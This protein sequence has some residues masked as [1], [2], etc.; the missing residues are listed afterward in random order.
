MQQ[1]VNPTPTVVGEGIS[2]T[3]ESGRQTTVVLRPIPVREFPALLPL[4]GQESTLIERSLGMAAGALT[5]GSDPITPDSYDHLAGKFREIN[6]PFFN[7]CTRQTNLANQVQ[8][9]TVERALAAA[10]EKNLLSLVGGLSGSPSRPAG[11]SMPSGI[12]PSAS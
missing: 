2:I 5:D 11:P 9:K 4:L 8:G 10:I 6:L 7:Y 1:L 12:A 3:F